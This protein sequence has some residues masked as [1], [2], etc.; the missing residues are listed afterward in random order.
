MPNPDLRDWIAEI[1]AADQ[2]QR[3]S[4]AELEEEIGGIVDAFQ[5]RTGNKAV[6]FD[7]IPGF[8]SG[9][10]ILANILTSVPRINIT[11]GLP[12]SGRDIDLVQFWRRTM[13]EMKS[14]PTVTVASGPIQ[15]SPLS[16]IERTLDQP[17]PC[18]DQCLVAQFSGGIL[19]RRRV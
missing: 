14:I 16:S 12:P 10:R 2:L 7:D 19:D 18:H 17:A 4:G 13:R 11:L 5:R 15:D 6:L 1:E 8:P 3:V 9:Y